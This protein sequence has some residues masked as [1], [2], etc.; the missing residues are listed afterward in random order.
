MV[1]ELTASLACWAALDPGVTVGVLVRALI[2]P[3]FVIGELV[4]G[5]VLVVVVDF[6][7]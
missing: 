5:A 6:V 7:Y 3:V 1:T 2:E 4:A